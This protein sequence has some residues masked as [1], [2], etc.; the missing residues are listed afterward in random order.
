MRLLGKR[1]KMKEG[2]ISRYPRGCP[3][4][5]LQCSHPPAGGSTA[6]LCPSQPVLGWL[7]S[8]HLTSH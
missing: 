1:L 8:L 4:S 6:P 7:G 5:L 3:G 2:V